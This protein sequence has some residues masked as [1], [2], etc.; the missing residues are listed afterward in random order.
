MAHAAPKS[1]QVGQFQV[2]LSEKLGR[3][4]FGI[5]YK[6]KDKKG[7]DIAA[8]DIDISE[9]GKSAAQEAENFYKLKQIKH[10]NIVEIFE[11]KRDEN[12]VWIFMEQCQLG[13]LDRYFKKHFN[14]IRSDNSKMN[15]MTQIING[16]EFL[17]NISIIHRD[18]KPANILMS[19]GSK[20]DDVVVKLTDFGLTKFLD[21]NA[22]TSAM[23]T[24]AGTPLF[25]APEFW[26]RD[27]HGAISYNWSVDIYAAGLVYLAVIQAQK[28]KRL[29]PVIENA[30]DRTETNAV[31]MT[32]GQTMLL[33]EKTKKSDLQLVEYKDEDSTK[34]NAA[35]RLIEQMTCVKPKYRVTAVQ[36]RAQLESIHTSK[37]KVIMSVIAMKTYCHMQEKNHEKILS[38]AKEKPICP[39][40]ISRKTVW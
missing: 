29:S 14:D 8:K 5:V 19:T 10:H 24:A 25:M 4:G 26:N 34:I 11:V 28:D 15:L 20:P 37:P 6:A 40:P 36:V 31:G 18:I 2:F 32:I 7:K 22:T 23:S 3:G 38:H 35:K 30:S 39:G 13:D 1:I 9:H 17:H 12:D 33:K 27:E 21:P 16:I